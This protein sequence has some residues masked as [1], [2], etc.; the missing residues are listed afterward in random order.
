MLNINKPTSGLRNLALGSIATAICPCYVYSTG[1][2]VLGPRLNKSTVQKC[3]AHVPLPMESCG[4]DFCSVL[5]PCW[6]RGLATPW[7]YFLHLSQSS[8]ILMDSSA[9]SPVHVLM[10][11]QAVRGL[12]RLRAPGIVPT[13]TLRQCQSYDRLTDV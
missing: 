5:Q 8:V 12:P 9:G 3:R 4:P 6:I 13:I 10:S 11:I 7:T 2:P 1:C